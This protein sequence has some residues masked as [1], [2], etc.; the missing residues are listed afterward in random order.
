MRIIHQGAPWNI[1]ILQ[2]I[3]LTEIW[4]EFFI[5]FIMP[6]NDVNSRAEIIMGTDKNDVWVDHVRLYEGK[7]VQDIEGAEPH[8]I[9]PNGKLATTWATLKNEE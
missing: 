5:T 1:Y 3:S 6:E 7:Y 8:A 4:K 9:E 2:V